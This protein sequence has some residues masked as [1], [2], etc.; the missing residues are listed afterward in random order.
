MKQTI[1]RSINR[2]LL[3][4]FLVTLVSCK[5]IQLVT[6]AQD[7]F[8]KAANI[9]NELALEIDYADISKFSNA[10]INYEIA[11]NLSSKALKNHKNRLKKDGLLG[12]AYSIKALSAW[13]LGEFNKADA[14]SK[15]ALEELSNQ[16]RDIALMKAIPGLIKAEQAFLKLGEDDNITIEKYNEI[17]GLITNPATGALNDITNASN[18]LDKGHPLLTYFQLARVS[19]LLTLDRADLRSGQNDATFVKNE[20][21]KGLKGLKNLVGCNSSTFK[22]FFDEL[23]S[24]GQVGCP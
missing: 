15:E 11:Y 16:P 7:N 12:T 13:K 8:N 4:I 23:G 1:Y 20:V 14:L 10:S 24:P 5:H 22:K 6:Q 17:K 9:E 19:M 3:I 2:I 21:I 18:G